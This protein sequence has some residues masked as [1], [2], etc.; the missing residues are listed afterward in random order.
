M[1]DEERRFGETGV[2]ARLFAAP[3][4]AGEKSTGEREIRQQANSLFM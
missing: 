4:F 1:A 3:V 2:G